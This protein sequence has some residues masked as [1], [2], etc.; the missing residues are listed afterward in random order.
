MSSIRLSRA[1]HCSMRANRPK[2]PASQTGAARP[3]SCNNLLAL[4]LEFKIL[5]SSQQTIVSLP[6]FSGSMSQR[7]EDSSKSSIKKVRP[8]FLM[9]SY[10]G[11]STPYGCRTS[12]AKLAWGAKIR[13]FSMHLLSGLNMVAQPWRFA[14]VAWKKHGYQSANSS[15]LTR[16]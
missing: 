6:I 10:E 11:R 8:L 12:P 2:E 15:H 3:R 7:L 16:V 14:Q 9:Q 1:S 13:D 4:V 5:E